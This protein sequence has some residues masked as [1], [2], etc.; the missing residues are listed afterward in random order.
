MLTVAA[1]L[2][3]GVEFPQALGCGVVLKLVIVT[4]DRI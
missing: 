4:I 1:Y 3:M 2:E